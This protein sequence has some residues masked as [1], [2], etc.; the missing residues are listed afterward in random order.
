MTVGDILA[1][2]DSRF[3]FA[4]AGDWDPVGL[5]IGGLSRGAERVGVCHEVTGSVVEAVFDDEIDCL[6]SYHPLMFVPTTSLIDGPAAE[7]LALRLAENGTSLIVVHTALDVATPGTGDA[8]IAEIG[9]SATGSFAPVD[10]MGGGDIGRIGKFDAPVD[11]DQFAATVENIVGSPVRTST[12]HPDSVETVGVV[13]G[14][15]GRFAADAAGLVDVYVSGDI[16]HHD[17]N[18]AVARGIGLIDAGHAPT[19]RP[20]VRALYAAVCEASPSATM[21]ND[22][23]HPWEG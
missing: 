12:I 9:L 19:E 18:E 2:L 20:G 16:G 14:S 17:A 22:D 8:M 1:A 11:F 15:G 5:Q 7:G 23:P 21:V 10:D 6:V 3:P 4:N 13:P